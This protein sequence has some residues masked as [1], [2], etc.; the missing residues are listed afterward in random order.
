[1]STKEKLSNEQLVVRIRAGE[2]VVENMEALYLQVKNFIHVIALRYQ[3]QAELD[4]LKQEGYLAL[5]DAVD[6]YEPDSGFLFLTDARHWIRQRMVRYIQNNG[7]V[8]LPV[9]EWERVSRYRKLEN[10]FLAQLGRKPSEAEIRC[11]LGLNHRQSLELQTALKMRQIGSLDSP[12]EGTEGDEAG[13]L[14]D[15]VA[16]SE[17]VEGAA[18]DKIEAGQLRAVLWQEVDS[19][20]DRQPEV[21]RARYQGGRTLKE[22]GAVLG[23]SVEAARQIERKALRGLRRSSRSRKLLPFL[24]EAVQAQAYR[25]NGA[26]EFNRTWTSSTERAALLEMER[27]LRTGSTMGT[28]H[29]QR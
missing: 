7:S 24:P 16:G 14:G 3:G 15:M 6:G 18:L 8:R 22:V 17:D 27:Y 5:Y 13:T 4:D 19:L 1:M 25:H 10:I 23:V 28:E 26:A 12:V 11:Y 9:Y 20:P 2:D 21:L 29:S